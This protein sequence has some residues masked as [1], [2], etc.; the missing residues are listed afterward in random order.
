MTS[1]STKTKPFSPK[2]WEM[3][4]TDP[5]RR[6]SMA[7]T[8]SPRRISASQ[9]CDPRKPAP[10]VTTT[11]PTPSAPTDG[12]VGEAAAADGGRVEEVAGVDQT[13]RGQQPADFLEVEPPELVPLR[14]HEQHGRP[15]A[16]CVRVGRHLEAVHAVGDSRVVGPNAGAALLEAVQDLDGG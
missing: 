6:L 10:P 7:T 5:V 2:R 8:S 11:R 9:M 4:S 3:L 16:R 12:V 1:Y 13:A 14:E 15:F